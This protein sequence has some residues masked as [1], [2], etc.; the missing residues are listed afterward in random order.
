[1]RRPQ[2]R[3]GPVEINNSIQDY[4]PVV[5]AASNQQSQDCAWPYLW[6]F[7][8]IANTLRDFKWKCLLELGHYQEQ[9]S[10]LSNGAAEDH[11]QLFQ[12]YGMQRFMTYL[13]K[14][15]LCEQ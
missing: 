8:N 9:V 6:G 15:C 1:M 10:S 12:I 13:L 5:L 11:Q 4:G 3:L 2:N 14:R 7:R